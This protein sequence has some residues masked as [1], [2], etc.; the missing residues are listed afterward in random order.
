M[1]S[2][3]QFPE[4]FIENLPYLPDAIV[5]KLAR[6]N[7]ALAQ[8]YHALVLLNK[9]NSETAKLYWQPVIAELKHEQRAILANKLLNAKRWDD[10]NELKVAGLLPEGDAS[11]H[12]KLRQST[13]HTMLNQAFMHKHG[14][15]LLGDALNVNSQCLFNVLMMSDHREGLYKLEALAARFN[16]QPEPKKGVFCFSAPMYVAGAIECA[17]QKIT[18]ARCNWE[19]A[20]I[21]RHLPVNFDFAIMMPKQGSANVSDAIMHINAKASYDVFLHELMHFNGFEDEYALPQDKQAWLCKKNG[22]VAPNLF[23]AREEMPPDGWYKSQSCQQ[24][25]VAYKPSKNWSIM[26]YQQV[27]LSS[28]YRLLWLAHIKVHHAAFIR[29]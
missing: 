13:P 17:E 7:V 23:I 14:F 18:I 6:K 16:T 4:H 11:N 25:G 20:Q 27:G 2:Y 5:A 12:L 19:N 10:L 22:F 29:F 8:Y 28:Q 3:W 1:Q 15:L 26:Q 24:G 21:K 9:Q